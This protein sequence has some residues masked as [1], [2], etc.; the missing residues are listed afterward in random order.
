M[1]KSIIP[2]SMNF[3]TPILFITYKRFDEALEVF[4]AIASVRP[5]RLYFASNKNKTNVA[6]EKHQI[7]R[8]RS[9]VDRIDWPCEVFLRYPSH[10]LNVQQSIYNAITWFFD[11]EEAGII[12]EDD[13]VPH[14]DFFFYCQ[15]LLGRYREE[16]C[17]WAISGNS[18]LEDRYPLRDS[19]YFSKYFHCWGWASWRRVW[20][21][22]DLE[23]VMLPYLLSNYSR[24][25]LFDTFA[26][27]AYWLRL[28]KKVFTY[29]VPL[30]W[31][32]QFLFNILVNRG[33]VVYPAKNLVKNIGFGPNAENTTDGMSPLSHVSSLLPIQHPRFIVRNSDAD[34]YNF[35][36]AYMKKSCL[37]L[38]KYSLLGLLDRTNLPG[39][40]SQS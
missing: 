22:F 17:I 30:T 2:N 40:L 39:S 25:S 14:Q 31:D 29:G 36:T 33:L 12:L 3:N 37:S 28:W 11:H 34:K 16:S 35:I 15:E 7:S 6:S 19:Y 32:Y 23:M 27:Q 20:E 21:R 26:E 10:H 8:V 18:F 24:Y 1:A 13:C 5:S 4:Q 9:L 38:C